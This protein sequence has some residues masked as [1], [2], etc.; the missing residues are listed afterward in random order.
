MS[1]NLNYPSVGK[2][3]PS[4]GF[5]DNFTDIVDQFGQIRSKQIQFAGGDLTGTSQIVGTGAGLILFTAQIRD[6][7]ELSGAESMLIPQGLTSE[8]PSTPQRGQLRFNQTIIA[9]EGFNGSTWVTLS[10]TGGSLSAEDEGTDLGVSVNTLNFIGP[11]VLAEDAGGGRID[12]KIAGGGGGGGVLFVNDIPARDLL[13]TV[14]GELV[15]VVNDSITADGIPGEGEWAMFLRNQ[16]DTAWFEVGTERR[17]DADHVESITIEFAFDDGALQNIGVVPAGRRVVKVSV[18]VSVP[19]DTA[20]T[21]VIGTV[22]SPSLLMLASENDL[23]GV[24]IYEVDP[25]L[26]AFLANTGIRASYST[27]GT[28]T[29]GTARVTIAYA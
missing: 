14:G 7:P 18:L 27:N 25:G 11:G 28:P 4:Q 2:N 5:R 26:G 22:S 3:Q 21:L 16:T 1:I 12:V 17:G 15:L 20:A 10:G 23:Q 13:I 29:L 24:F 6:N 9:F 8:R 19:W